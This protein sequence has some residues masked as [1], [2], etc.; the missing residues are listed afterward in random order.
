[1]LTGKVGS[2][3][4]Q[5]KIYARKSSTGSGDIISTGDSI[6]VGNDWQD[7]IISWNGTTY[8]YK[9]MGVT[10]LNTVSLDKLVSF[11]TWK[12]STTSGQIRNIKIKP[13]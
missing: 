13:L 5:Y 6:T 12:Q 2:G 7:N 9:G 3:D 10:D 11:A 8:S 4:S 1:M